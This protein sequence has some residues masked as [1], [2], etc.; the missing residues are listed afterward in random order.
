MS[1]LN[2]FSNIPLVALMTLH[3]TAPTVGHESTLP[4]YR[5]ACTDSTG[6]LNTDRLLTTYIFRS[7]IRDTDYYAAAVTKGGGLPFATPLF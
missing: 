5:T 7:V 2:G 4:P 3:G 6:S 1:S